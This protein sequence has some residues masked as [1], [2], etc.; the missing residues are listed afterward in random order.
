[1]T[2]FFLL[3]QVIYYLKSGWKFVWSFYSVVLLLTFI[4]YFAVQD[5]SFFKFLKKGQRLNQND[6]KYMLSYFTFCK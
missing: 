2:V 6:N 5:K 3:F 1:M 4:I